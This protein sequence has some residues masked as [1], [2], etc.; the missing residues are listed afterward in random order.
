MKIEINEKIEAYGLKWFLSNA[1]VTSDGVVIFRWS[2]LEAPLHAQSS[3]Q[4]AYSLYAVQFEHGAD[5]QTYLRRL[6]NDKRA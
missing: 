2:C 3:G 6:K 1:H 4:C 5:L